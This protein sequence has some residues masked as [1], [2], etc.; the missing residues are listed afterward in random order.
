MRDEVVSSGSE[1]LILVDENDREIGVS[2]KTDCHL[3]DGVLHRAFSLFIFNDAGE[4]LLQ[5]RSSHK[6]LWPMFWSNSC[7]SHPRE[8]ESMEHAVDRR[9]EQEL[10]L[11]TDLTFLYKF[12]YH[13]PYLDIGAEH[14]FCWVYAG[15]SSDVPHANVNEV[16][17]MR[18]ISPM[19]LDQEMEQDPDSFTPWFKL[20]WAR[21]RELYVREQFGL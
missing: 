14:E 11:S 7:C 3:G 9:L 19:Q 21:V 13:A 16:D 12:V 4:L 1:Q 8:G 15:Q 5:R 2:S 20:E 18:Y 17:E 6:P 10:G